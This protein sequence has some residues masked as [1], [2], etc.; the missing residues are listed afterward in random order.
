MMSCRR[1]RLTSRAPIAWRLRV[2][3]L[4][5]ALA[6]TR[7]SERAPE[8]RRTSVDSLLA[9]GESLFV[10]EKYDSARVVYRAALD[11]ARAARDRDRETRALT[12]IAFAAYSLTDFEDARKNAEQS[13]ALTRNGPPTQTLAKTYNV[14]GLVAWNEDRLVEAGRLLEQAIQL[15][16]TTN[17]SDVLARASGNLGLVAMNLGDLR[18]A[19]ESH[20]EQRRLARALGDARLEGN[21]FANEANV[22]VWEGNPRAAFPRLDTARTLYERAGFMRGQQFALSI[23]STAYENVGNVDAAF[24]VLDTALNLARQLSLK[25]QEAEVLRLLSEMHLNVGD[26][27]RAVDYAERAERGLSAT[28]YEIQR[29]QALRLAADAYLRL[30]NLTRAR[31]DAETAFR[32]DSAAAQ[33]L[34]AL[35]DLLLLSEI[36]Y[37]ARGLA[38]A[39]PRLR[40]ALEI[41]DRL[42]TRG[43]R[44]AVA[45]AEAHIADAS[46]NPQR[47]LRALRGAGPDIAAGDFA[48]AWETNALAARAFAR[49]N[50]LDSAV[51]AGRRAIGA[52]ERLRGA[53]ASDALRSTYVADR[54]GVYS[55]LALALLRLRREDEA[56]AV[57]DAARSGELLR[58][59]GAARDDAR[60]GRL[61]RELMETDELLRRIDQLVQKLRESERGR[62]RERGESADSAD[63]LLAQE[64][65]RARA[66][67]EALSIRLAQEHPRAFAVLGTEATR[68][69]D[70]RSSLRSGEALLDYLVTPERLI[71]FVVT[72]TKLTVVQHALRQT[73]LTQRVRLLHDLW[74][75]PTLDWKWGLEAAKAL[76]GDLIAPVRDAGLLR[77]V[78][79]VFVVP[80]GILAQ[81]PFPAL[82]DARTQRYLV[83]DLSV[84]VLPS[85]GVLPALRRDP[86]ST[87]EWAGRGV[88]LAPFPEELPATRGEVEAFRGLFPR[89]TVRL[90]GEATE[91]DLRRALALGVPV[92]VATHAVINAR[93][94]MFS[95]IELARPRDGRVYD[96]GRLEL[97]EVLGLSVRSP[98]VFL[99]GCETGAAS[100]WTDDPVKG[101]AE[102]TLAQA[103]LS[104]GAA[105][106]I[107]TLWRIDDA[108]AGEFAKTFY[109]A[110]S[111]LGIDDALSETQRRMA[112]DSRYANPYYWAGYILTGP[113]TQEAADPSVSVVTGRL[114]RKAAPSALRP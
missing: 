68:T 45:V 101:T 97:H 80:Q 113:G 84:T 85:A 98:L 81:V 109:A 9:A 105:N 79:H 107:L 51:A 88:A 13:L 71:V 32:L 60:A 91:A 69:D 49:L 26:Y 54:A 62:R 65:E 106:V 73:V 75:S 103:F 28:G 112:T 58:R 8:A 16:R 10:H 31:S 76:D 96:D 66:D 47:V 25:G 72:P 86:V 27:R 20:R 36:D 39:E 61:P 55:D 63:A 21:S 53:L 94:P 6:C 15:A 2:G 57:A 46:N 78:R 17:D 108:G 22:D 83:Q 19:R 7:G 4:L 23:L 48:A 33:P 89:A 11:R 90:G 37:R 43:S 44:I 77:G 64:L 50:E 14:L 87:S 24:A 5:A 52:V 30:G 93:N 74:G 100:E 102:L 82:V 3:C 70:V 67:Y 111:R 35:D 29:A 95:R 12:A 38:G 56:F 41:A 34:D 92:H 59:L 110:L 40:S 42:G 1:R 104:A 18:R 99:S 114:G